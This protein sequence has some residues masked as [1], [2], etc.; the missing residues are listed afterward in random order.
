MQNEAI[1]LIAD[2]VEKIVKG[3][4]GR[5]EEARVETKQDDRGWLITV[6]VNP[7]ETGK[8]IGSGGRTIDAIRL[9]VHCMSAKPDLR[10][11][12][13]VFDPRKAA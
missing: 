13:K 9:L 10:I 1:A 5:P 7:A 11:G 6:F 4:V 8:V 12:V 3:I 2:V